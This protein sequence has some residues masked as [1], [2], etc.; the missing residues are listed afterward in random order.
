M[1]KLS[2]EHVYMRAAEAGMLGQWKALL[3][4]GDGGEDE[5][6][7]GFVLVDWAGPISFYDLEAELVRWAAKSLD[8]ESEFGRLSHTVLAKVAEEM[9]L[10]ANWPAGSDSM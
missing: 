4:N 3:S 6:D 10:H 5:H 2:F 1:H 9:K 7:W 8:D